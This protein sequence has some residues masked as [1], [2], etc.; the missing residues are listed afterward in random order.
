NFLMGTATGV[1][2]SLPTGI[3]TAKS[4]WGLFIQDTWKF[5]RK[6]TFDLG[7]RWD[8]GTYAKE[9]YGRVANFSATVPNPNA[10]GHPGGSIFEAT[11]NCTFADN[12]PYAIGPRIGVAYQINSKTV[13]RA[14][15]GIVY[16][17]TSTASGTTSN[18]ANAGNPLFGGWVS[19]L[20]DGIPSNVQPQWPV[21]EAGIGMT[22]NSIANP[23][24]NLD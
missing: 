22:P 23:P 14:G 5:N 13:I 2:L 11:C 1:S 10:G 7:L 8:Y 17:A 12:Y 18:S 20:K 24:T 21:Y 4:Q 9:Q 15:W 16:N 6:L 3:R 19:L